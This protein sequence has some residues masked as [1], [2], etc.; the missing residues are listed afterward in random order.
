[1]NLT[2]DEIRHVLYNNGLSAE[3]AESIIE[4]LKDK[5]KLNAIQKMQQIEKDWEAKIEATKL[6][7]N[8]KVGAL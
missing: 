8:T 5:I 4:D 7:K 6:L 1:M 3:K 2:Y